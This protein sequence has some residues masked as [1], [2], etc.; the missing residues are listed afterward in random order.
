VDGSKL[1]RPR[2]LQL[3]LFLRKSLDYQDSNNYHL[4]QFG[5]WANHDISLMPPDTT[6]KIA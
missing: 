3:Q 1:P 5:Q 4:M 2:Q 6:G